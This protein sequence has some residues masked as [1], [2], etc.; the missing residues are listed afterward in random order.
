MHA[1][2][3]HALAGSSMRV[4]HRKRDDVHADRHAQQLP[5][6]AE[7]Q[8]SGQWAS[9][10]CACCSKSH[11]CGVCVFPGKHSDGNVHRAGENIL[12]DDN[13]VSPFATAATAAITTSAS[14]FDCV[15]VVGRK[16]RLTRE[17]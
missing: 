6:A 3:K 7:R 13:C 15:T 2:G 9:E 17:Q 8:A 12:R 4:R 14:A 1:L 16:G 5:S 10:Q 11:L